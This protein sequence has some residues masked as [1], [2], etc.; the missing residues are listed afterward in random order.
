MQ[1]IDD[2]LPKEIYQQILTEING[3]NFGWFYR[4][5]SSVDNDNISQFVHTF[6]VDDKVN[7]DFFDLVIPIMTMFELKTN[8][9]VKRLHRAKANLLL[10]TPY[11]ENDL[12]KAIHQDVTN[13]SGISLLYYVEDS[14]GDTIVYNE[15][16]EKKVNQV[17]PKA[18]RAFIFKADQWHNATPPKEHRTRKVINF[19]FE[20]E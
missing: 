12:K 7:S 19:I 3:L 8:Y 15:T 5:Y 10:N 2:F 11:K 9:K 14:D 4:D 18:N 16:K 13:Q 20:V 1:I 17:P 6:Y